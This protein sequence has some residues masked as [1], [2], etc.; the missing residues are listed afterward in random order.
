M[1]ERI[2][3]VLFNIPRGLHV[4]RYLSAKDMK[5]PP[6]VMVAGRPGASAGVGFL[7]A[8]DAIENTL[9]RFGDCVAIMAPQASVLLVT[10]IGQPESLS[11]DVELKL[12]PLD[13]E[14]SAP[15]G[16]T[17][18]AVAPAAA[19]RSEGPF[20]STAHVQRQG[21]VMAGPDGWIGAPQSRNRIESFAVSWV[22]PVKGLRLG[23]GCEMPGRGRH[24]ARVPGQAVGTKGQA[25]PINLVHFELTGSAASAWELVVSAAFMGGE[26]RTAAGRK[27]ELTG[28]TGQEALVGLKVDLRRAEA[29]PAAA[30]EA[31]APVAAPATPAPKAAAAALPAAVERG[32]VRVFRASA[33]SRPN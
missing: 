13:R 17:R 8:P 6:R 32:R 12:E 7:F 5:R 25:T 10:A 1:T 9:S 33:A 2:S 28:R 24:S 20:A 30:A 23:Y 21:D 16:E 22:A 27:V 31:K 14:A 11:T 19:A 15:R 3:T 29:Q 18:P 26:V 4:L